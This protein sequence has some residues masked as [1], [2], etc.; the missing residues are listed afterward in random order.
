MPH[1]KKVGL[2]TMF[3][4]AI[5]AVNAL[6][7]TDI[8]LPSLPAMMHSLS[9][10][11]PQAQSLISVYLI[12]ISLMHLVYG[13]ISDSFGRKP[14]LVTSLLIFMLSSFAAGFSE[15]YSALFCARLF[16]ALGACAC[17]VLGKAIVADVCT[18]EESAKIFL[19]IFPAVG[20]TCSM[21]PIVG[22]IISNMF[23]W[24]ANFYFLGCINFL[25][26]LATILFLKETH[27]HHKRISL[28]LQTISKNTL[29]VLQS[30]TFWGYS[31]AVCISYAAYFIYIAEAPFLVVQQGVS[32]AHI[33]YTFIT[34]SIGYVLGNLLCGNT[35]KHMPLDN[36][37]LLGYILLLVGAS[38]FAISMYLFPTVFSS[39]ITGV[40][41]ISFGSGYLLP[42]GTAGAITARP[43]LPGLTSGVLGCLYLAS[44]G[45]VS[46]FSGII[47]HH[48]PEKIG[49]FM[50][51]VSWVGFLL[52]LKFY[53]Y[54]KKSV[55]AQLK[56]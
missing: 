43:K 56:N 10:S 37:L 31:G 6:M 27:P 40:S 34:I 8:M 19:I 49:L 53:F 3:I 42:L 22:G 11:T 32:S 30:T 2:V 25:L 50:A 14:I 41:L 12:G 15:S 20:A 7:G 48:N 16:Q 51:I 55:E 21:A 26:L 5:M 45:A 47:T 35:Q 28:D 17:L 24:T 23:N 4:I 52:H 38:W 54:H 9:L 33:G 18:K 1:K 39:S 46:Q 36:K 44:G 29:N 13:P